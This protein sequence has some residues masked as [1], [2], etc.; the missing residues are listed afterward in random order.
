SLSEKR[1]ASLVEL[2]RKWSRKQRIFVLEDAAYRGLSFGAG[3]PPSVWSHDSEGDTV[4]LARTFSKTLSPGF[5]IGYGVLP[6]TLVDPVLCLKGNHDFGSANFNQRLL[7]RVLRDGSYEHHLSQL[8]KIYGRKCNAFL[9]ALDEY[10][11]PLDLDISWTR[12]EGGLFV[13]MTV[14]ED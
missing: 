13:W 1:R 8:A 9:A 12:P 6:H 14:G 7:D 4:I 10:I 5:K 3:E 2:A 11:R